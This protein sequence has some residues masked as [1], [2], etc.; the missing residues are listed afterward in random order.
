LTSRALRHCVSSHLRE[1]VA[2][3]STEK[4][5]QDHEVEDGKL[6]TELN[7]P[8]NSINDYLAS[9]K[10]KW[11]ADEKMLEL[12]ARTLQYSQ[13]YIQDLEMIH[14]KLQQILE[15]KNNRINQL[16][17]EIEQDVQTITDNSRNVF[18]KYKEIADQKKAEH[19]LRANKA[20]TYRL[21]KICDI[22]AALEY[23]WALILSKNPSKRRESID[24]VLQWWFEKN[25]E[26]L[27]KTCEANELN[28]ESVKACVAGLYDASCKRRHG[29][30]Y[31][32]VIFAEYWNPNEVFALALLLKHHDLQFTYSDTTDTTDMTVTDVDRRDAKFP[33]DLSAK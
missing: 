30:E 17:G 15:E 8:K 31:R 21:E 20:R 9:L 10:R 22:K 4:E 6:I 1:G 3:K 14:D 19:P 5:N 26:L 25:S 24:A 11:I 18:A 7:V 23:I 29:R 12:S 13:M 2:H 27:Q 16:K 28:V 33:Y 32:I